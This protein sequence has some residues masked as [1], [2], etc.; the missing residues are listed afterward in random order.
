MYIVIIIQCN[1]WTVL[2]LVFF[3]TL[4]GS[5]IVDKK[6]RIQIFVI[7]VDKDIMASSGSDVTGVTDDVRG[8]MLEV[9]NIKLKS[10]ILTLQEKF[11]QLSKTNFEQ[12][13]RNMSPRI[14]STIKKMKTKI[15]MKKKKS[16]IESSSKEILSL[17]NESESSVISEEAESSVEHRWIFVKS[18]PQVYNS[19]VCG[20]GEDIN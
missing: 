13:T 11:T 4:N 1:D 15:M 17:E 20:G 9:E 10:Q 8:R 16:K 12:T 19:E 7:A 5:R 3:R 6:E 14:I 2:E 18:I